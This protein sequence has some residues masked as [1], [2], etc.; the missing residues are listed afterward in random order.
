MIANKQD[1]QAYGRP[2][3]DDDMEVTDPF[4]KVGRDRAE[5]HLSDELRHAK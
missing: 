2:S 5:G 3:K 1:E 4:G